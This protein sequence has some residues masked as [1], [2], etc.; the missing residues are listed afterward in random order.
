MSSE[1]M[2]KNKFNGRN[3]I[4]GINVA[5]LRNEHS[6]HWSQRE[7]SD[8]LQLIGHD[9]DKNAVQKMENGERFINDIELVALSR[10]FGVDVASLL[11]I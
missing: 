4:A 11:G 8:Q 2:Y 3:N 10:V 7:L 5:R 1:S 6:P 9:I